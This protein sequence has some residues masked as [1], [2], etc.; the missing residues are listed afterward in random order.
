[1][2]VPEL[3]RTNSS[4]ADFRTLIVALDADLRGKYAD[5]MDTYDQHNVIDQIDTVI[6]A[7]LQGE[8]VA[9]GCF[10]SYDAESVEVKRMY[11]A[12][13]ARGKGISKMILRNLEDWARDLGYSYTVLETASKQHE[14]IGLYHNMGYEKTAQY[15]PYVDLPDSICFRKALS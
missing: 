13:A 11:V 2:P 9:C 6:V 14:A 12:P 1:M 3:R 4:D 5:L 10:K 8:A 7:T 15:G